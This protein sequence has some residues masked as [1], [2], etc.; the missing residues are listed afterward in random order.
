M[1]VLG[2]GPSKMVRNDKLF[3]IVS[4]HV[5]AICKFS[6]ILIKSENLA[7]WYIKNTRSRNSSPSVGN[8]EVYI[9]LFLGALVL[10]CL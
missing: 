6:F 9:F 7:E 3:G 8:Q 4:D 1:R 2:D 10:F 5:Y